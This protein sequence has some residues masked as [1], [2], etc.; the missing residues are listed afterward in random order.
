MRVY[1]SADTPHVPLRSGSVFVR[2][3]A[4]DAD[5][6]NPGRPGAGARGDRIYK[7]TQIRSR[8]QLLELATRGTMAAQRVQ[9]LVDPVRP[10]PLTNTQLLLRFEEL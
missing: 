7:A 5:V 9:A 2:E 10:L 4:G 8:A 6:V 1:E 3:V